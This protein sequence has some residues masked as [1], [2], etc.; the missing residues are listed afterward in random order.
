MITDFEVRDKSKEL[1]QGGDGQ[2]ELT[3]ADMLRCLT[4]Y[5]L[6]AY[7]FLSACRSR[8]PIAELQPG[9]LHAGA[10]DMVVSLQKT[11]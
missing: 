8:G 9:T 7:V 6:C 11:R 2:C 3:A 5:Y 1:H 4:Y 10:R